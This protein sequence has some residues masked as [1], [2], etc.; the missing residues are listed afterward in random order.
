MINYCPLESNI[1]AVVRFYNKFF[2]GLLPPVHTISERL[3]CDIRRALMLYG[4]RCIVEV[5]KEVKFLVIES[6]DARDYLYLSFIMTDLHAFRALLDGNYRRM[7]RKGGR[8]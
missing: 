5:F 8:A 2:D 7:K 3:S 1:K 4:E 6:K